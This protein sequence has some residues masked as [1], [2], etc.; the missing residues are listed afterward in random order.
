MQTAN[1]ACLRNN[2]RAANSAFGILPIRR[3]GA[4]SM[5]LFRSRADTDADLDL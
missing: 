4:T 3:D 1:D 2:D 5:R